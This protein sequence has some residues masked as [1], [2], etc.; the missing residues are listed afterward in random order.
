[1]P[2]PIYTFP[3]STNNTRGEHEPPAVGMHFA[4]RDHQVSAEKW[5]PELAHI[6]NRDSFKS[7][8]CGLTSMGLEE[9]LNAT[10]M[11]MAEIE[12]AQKVE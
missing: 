3:R 7:G 5:A 12:K 6:A 2:V 8:L 1:V 11:R 4:H 10:R 9:A